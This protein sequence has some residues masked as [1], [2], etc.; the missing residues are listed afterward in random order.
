MRNLIADCLHLMYCHHLSVV[1][2][3]DLLMLMRRVVCDSRS[4]NNSV[5]S[6]SGSLVPHPAERRVSKEYKPD[7]TGFWT[8]LSWKPPK[9]H[10]HL[11]I[12]KKQSLPKQLRE[13]SPQKKK[14]F[15][16]C[17][18]SNS[19]WNGSNKLLPW[20]CSPSPCLLAQQ[21]Q[22]TSAVFN[23]PDVMLMV[24]WNCGSTEAGDENCSGF[25]RPSLRLQAPKCALI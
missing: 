7:Y 21:T 10:N 19:L 18:P 25:S 15:V 22:T 3:K 20:R 6:T 5:E 12:W 9:T 17:Y 11:M 13:S 1:F 2:D 16:G 14:V 4:R 8:V 24:G 23:I